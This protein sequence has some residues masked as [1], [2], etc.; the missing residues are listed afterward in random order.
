MAERDPLLAIGSVFDR[1][2]A[3]RAGTCTAFRQPQHVLTAAHCVETLEPAEV[4]V[5]FIAA[6]GRHAAVEIVPHPTA[7]LALVRLAASGDLHGVQP[8]TAVGRIDDWGRE[9]AGL[10]SADGAATVDEARQRLLTGRIR[11]TFSDPAD[12]HLYAELSVP[13]LDGFS[14]GPLFAPGTPHPLL[15][16]ITANRRPRFARRRNPGRG[17]ALLAGDLADWIDE[18]APAPAPQHSPPVAGR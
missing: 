15:A 12:G 1:R 14:G 17:I 5:G 8:L 4:E 16:V 9:F 7:D 2:G 10:G 13:A 3:R 6:A 11:G 18:H